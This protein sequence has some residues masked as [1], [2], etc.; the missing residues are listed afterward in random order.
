MSKRPSI[1]HM[2]P[3][4]GSYFCNVCSTT[5]TMR[6]YIVIYVSNPTMSTMSGDTW[7]KHTVVKMHFGANVVKDV[8][9]DAR[10]DQR[11]EQST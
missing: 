10:T 8:F 2:M 3:K 5:T 4:S 9:R 6:K 11:A 7:P 1:M